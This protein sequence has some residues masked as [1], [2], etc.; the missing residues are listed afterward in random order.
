MIIAPRAKKPVSKTDSRIAKA[1]FQHSNN[2]KVSAINSMT[3]STPPAPGECMS[4]VT[5]GKHINAFAFV[6]YILEKEIVKALHIA[7]YCM[8]KKVPLWCCDLLEREQVDTVHFYVSCN[9]YAIKPDVKRV[10]TEMTAAA[11]DLCTVKYFHNHAKIALIETESNHYVLT[12]S[13]NFSD[14]A[15]TEIYELKNDKE[16]FDF[17]VGWLSDVQDEYI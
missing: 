3:L 8:T 2:R 10:L 14:N 17:H 6:Q 7:T 12:G 15:I 9:P 1:K 5:T 4:I 11:P 16:L 13:G